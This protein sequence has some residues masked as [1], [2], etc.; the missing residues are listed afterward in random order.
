MPSQAESAAARVATVL[1]AVTGATGGVFRDRSEAFSREEGACILVELVSDDATPFSGGRGTDQAE[2]RIAVIYLTRATSWQTVVDAMRVQAH[3]LIIGDATLAG[4][5]GGL[6]RTRAEWHAAL[7]D[8]PLGY[9]AQQYSGKYL[10]P[11]SA[12][13]RLS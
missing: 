12:L 5:I 3:G 4:L 11:T 13:S 8:L 1:A 9:C 10:S 7:A 2:W 6:H